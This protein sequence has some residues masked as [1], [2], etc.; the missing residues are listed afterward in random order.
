MHK[1]L[2]VLVACVLVASS[3][4]LAC[5]C[6]GGSSVAL[7]N[8]QSWDLGDIDAVTISY[9]SD[10]ITFAEASSDLITI[11]EY[12]T[13]SNTDYFAHVEQD[14]SSLVVTSGRRPGTG[15][16]FASHV[17][18]YLPRSYQGFLGVTTTSGS[19][20]FSSAHNLSSL[21]IRTDSGNISLPD[22]GA[23]GMALATTT[24]RISVTGGSGALV[25]TSDS[26][27]ISVSGMR[28][29]I[30]AKTDAGG[31]DVSCDALVG[32]VVL[33]SGAGAVS[34][35]VPGQ[36][37][38]L[39]DADCEQSLLQTDFETD[40]DEVG[41]DQ[42]AATP[43]DDTPQATDEDSPAPSP[44]GQDE[45]TTTRST[46][47]IGTGAAAHVTLRSNTGRVTMRLSS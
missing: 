6:S 16:T 21:Q 45:E 20:T 25:A 12:M 7:Q 19:V 17:E 30:S 18:V 4:L 39:F 42:M 23:S 29:P 1:K 32:D 13:E 3:A 15:S 28:G 27:R 5:G 43:A 44:T 2:F 11:K 22:A 26:G 35:T 14:G 47:T 36:S 41:Q 38:V 24:G 34:L 37:A 9:Q 10:N 40:T 46:A 33:T 31:I 8:S